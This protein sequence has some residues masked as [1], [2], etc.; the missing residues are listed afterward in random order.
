MFANVVLFYYVPA[1]LIKT[2]L[3]LDYDTKRS[4]LGYFWLQGKEVGVEFKS[5]RFKDA[6]ARQLDEPCPGPNI[7]SQFYFIGRR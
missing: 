3:V 5:I 6:S 2:R 4:S 7:D 1:K